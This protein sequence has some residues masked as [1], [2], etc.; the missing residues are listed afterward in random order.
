MVTRVVVRPPTCVQHKGIVLQSPHGCATLLVT[1]ELLI[2][3]LMYVAMILVLA[4][5]GARSLM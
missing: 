1:S 4:T 3:D 2:R 5:S